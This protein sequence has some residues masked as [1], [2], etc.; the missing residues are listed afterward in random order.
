MVWL[1][2]A[3][4][5]DHSTP[6]KCGQVSD[7]RLDVDVAGC[8]WE[9]LMKSVT[10][11]NVT[12]SHRTRERPAECLASLSH[13]TMIE[14]GT[15][16]KHAVVSSPRSTSA[17]VARGVMSRLATLNFTHFSRRDQ[18]RNYIFDSFIDFRADLTAGSY[19]CCPFS[20][21]PRGFVQRLNISDDSYSFVRDL[22]HRRY[23]YTWRLA[24]YFISEILN[25]PSVAGAKYRLRCTCVETHFLC[26]SDK[27][28][29]SASFVTGLRTTF[30]YLIM[31]NASKEQ[32]G[33]PQTTSGESGNTRPRNNSPWIGCR[34]GICERLRGRRGEVL[35][36]RV[37]HRNFQPLNKM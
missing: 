26:E 6:L 33:L 29:G 27:V 28:C 10:L 21:Q 4:I 23:Q 1:V 32:C 22:L 18:D 5:T 13:S 20:K 25:L 17:A 31:H 30:S 15:E 11:G 36:K 8:G 12:M 3:A 37:D 35:K 14:F 34:N 2:V 24:D 7:G 16:A 9:S 19:I